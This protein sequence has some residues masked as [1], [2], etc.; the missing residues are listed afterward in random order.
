MVLCMV[1]VYCEKEKGGIHSFG[2]GGV[3]G[4]SALLLLLPLRFRASFVFAPFLP[5]QPKNEFPS[6]PPPHSQGAKREVEEALKSTV[7]T[8]KISEYANKGLLSLERVQ[9]ENL[10]RLFFWQESSFDLSKHAQTAST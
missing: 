7:S 3:V 2:G 5:N 8:K 10:F 6:P 1:A 4:G 9:R